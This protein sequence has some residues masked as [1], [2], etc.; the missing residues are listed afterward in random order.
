MN[1]QAQ[2]WHPVLQRV[3]EFSATNVLAALE[4]GQPVRLTYLNPQ[5]ILSSD[6]NLYSRYNFLRSDGF[7]LVYL[8]SRAFKREVERASFDFSSIAGN[9][10][11][12]LSKKSIQIA[13]V[14]GKREHADYFSDLI[15]QKFDANVCYKSDGY[16]DDREVP[17]KIADIVESNAKCVILG[18]GGEKQDRFGAQL[19]SAGYG[20]SIFCCGAFISQ[21]ASVGEAY[22][23]RWAL[24]FELRWLYRFFKEPHVI[25]RVIKYYPR[26]F[27]FVR[28]VAQFRGGSGAK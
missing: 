5:K 8:L 3:S 12:I 13:I 17:V 14:G 16:F 27:F 23:P 11:N 10:F 20:G 26:A 4:S 22:Y 18:L 25:G 21:T 6:P 24:K 15:K 2:L 1:M 19:L 9:V 28:S 7:Y